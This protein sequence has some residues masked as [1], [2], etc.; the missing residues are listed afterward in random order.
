MY[1]YVELIFIFKPLEGILLTI[2]ML[3]MNIF[4]E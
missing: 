3:N 2:K 4:C 1:L